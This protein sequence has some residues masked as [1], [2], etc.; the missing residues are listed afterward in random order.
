MQNKRL[1]FW[2]GMLFLSTICVYAIVHTTHTTTSVA[3][4]T[5][6]DTSQLIKKNTSCDCCEK[7][8]LAKQRVQ[9]RLRKQQAERHPPDSS[10]TP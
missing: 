1:F 9:E 4:D 8:N 6:T 2:I 5:N 10:Q 7:I 3:K